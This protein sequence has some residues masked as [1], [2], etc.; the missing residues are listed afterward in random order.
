MHRAVAR[1][2][3]PA[4][5]RQVAVAEEAARRRQLDVTLQE[6]R[7]HAAELARASEVIDAEITRVEADITALEQERQT[8]NVAL[9]DAEARLFFL[10]D[11]LA[12]LEAAEVEAAQQRERA[13]ELRAS[14]QALLARIDELKQRRAIITE[15][16]DALPGR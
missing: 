8:T 1:G 15:Q 5:R 4:Q 6:R 11:A 12:G 16:A 3:E 10:R 2:G 14:I 13:A 7:V 9:N